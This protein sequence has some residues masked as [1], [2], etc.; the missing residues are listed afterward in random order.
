MKKQ[1]KCGLLILAVFMI[2]VI[3]GCSKSKGS[4]GG[5]SKA[6]ATN[7]VNINFTVMSGAED[8]ECWQTIIDVFQRENPG[9]KVNMENVP[10]GWEG[11]TQK[12]N[13]LFAAGTPPDTGRLASLQK[14]MYNSMGRVVELSKFI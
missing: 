6:A 1:T 11:Y 4:G 10:G 7:V 5:E 9:I 14:P 12:L 13:T 8:V 3:A 2:F